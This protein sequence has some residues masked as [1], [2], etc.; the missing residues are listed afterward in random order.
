MNP[1]SKVIKVTFYIISFIVLLLSP[2][3]YD[4]YTYKSY[5]KNARKIEI[6]DDYNQV[7]SIMG[8]PSIEYE[9]HF[10]GSFMSNEYHEYIYGKYFNTPNLFSNTSPYISILKQRPLGKSRDDLVIQFN[11]RK[12]VISI[13]IPKK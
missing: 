5:L 13:L 12:K 1:S 11:D 7:I 3:T 2:I 4:I 9:K 6:G 10:L 8:K